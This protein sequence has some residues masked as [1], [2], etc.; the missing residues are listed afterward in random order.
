MD[1][2]QFTSS[3]LW[4]AVVAASIFYFRVPLRQ[5]LTEIRPTKLKALGFET[6][7]DRTLTNVEQITKEAESAGRA[8]EDS[9]YPEPGLKE[10][11]PPG[12]SPSPPKP[13]TLADLVRGHRHDAPTTED[14]SK[15]FVQAG[16]TFEEG[17]GDLYR[18]VVGSQALTMPPIPIEFLSPALHLSEADTAAI[19][20]LRRLISEVY[21]RWPNHSLRMIDVMRFRQTAASVLRNIMTEAEKPVGLKSGAGGGTA[22]LSSA[23]E[24]G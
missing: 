3:L 15:A 18:A 16:Q 21:A 2:L 6:E 5:I 11:Q 9:A 22:E 24:P 4:P 14:I 8:A 13:S 17:L 19:S 7:F 10:E 12:D 23:R 20:E 1:W